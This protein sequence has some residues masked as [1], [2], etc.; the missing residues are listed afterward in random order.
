MCTCNPLSVVFLCET[1]SPGYGFWGGPHQ[2]PISLPCTG[3]PIFMW[4][5]KVGTE[6]T[7]CHSWSPS[8]LLLAAFTL[9]L[10][11]LSP[12]VTGHEARAVKPWAD[13]L[14]MWYGSGDPLW[15]RWSLSSVFM[16]H[17]V[18]HEVGKW[19]E[20]GLTE[21]TPCMA[22]AGR[23]GICT[24]GSLSYDGRAVSATAMTGTAQIV[25]AISGSAFTNTV[26]KKATF[27]DCG[28]R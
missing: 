23:A 25:K 2:P 14:R 7:G 17:Q 19:Q 9:L 10:G 21:K 1:W 12:F 22:R 4:V 24:C 11:Q 28:P 5:Q 20:P 13:S 16:K 8:P 18:W 3:T 27:G 26:H 15:G 6:V